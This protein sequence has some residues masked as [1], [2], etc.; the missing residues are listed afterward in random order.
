MEQ[1]FDTDVLFSVGERYISKIA[2]DLSSSYFTINNI[3][4]NFYY[5]RKLLLQITMNNRIIKKN[6]K[7]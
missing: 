5:Y 7:L 4:T 6:F 3:V 2:K 1:M